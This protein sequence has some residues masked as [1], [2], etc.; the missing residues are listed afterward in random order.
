[1]AISDAQYAAWLKSQ[2]AVRCILVEV[3]V[4]VGASVI[5][6]YLSTQGYVTGATDT[7]A[8]TFYSPRIVGGLQ[9]SRKLSIDGNI[10]MSFG[11]IELN[12]VDGVLD[13]WIDD[14]WANRSLRIYLGDVSWA[15]AD[16]RLVFSGVTTGIDTR[17][18]TS[19]N[20]KLSD[21]LQNLNNPVSEV[22]LGGATSRADDLVPILLGECHNIEPLLTD[23]TINEYQVHNGPVESIFEVRD[24]GIP[25]AFTSLSAIGK[26]RLTNAP[27]GT[28]T[29]SAQGYAAT[30]NYFQY[31]QELDNVYWSKSNCSVTANATSAPDGTTTADKLVE[32]TTASVTHFVSRAVTVAA[33]LPYTLSAYFKAAERSRCRLSMASTLFVGS[34][35]AIVDLTN[36]AVIQEQD[37]TVTVS[38]LASGWYRISMTATTDA[39]G[40]ATMAVYPV[41][42]GT[43]QYTG[44][45]VSG[46]YVWGM[47]VEQSN[48][49][50]AYQPTTATP[51]NIY[52]KTVV[53]IIK[54]LATKYGKAN[55]QYTLNDLDI[56]S[57][58]QFDI[59]NPQQV[60]YYIKD[61]GNV[62]DVCNQLAQSIGARLVINNLGKLTL[63]KLDLPQ[64]SAGTTVTASDMVLK[65]LEISQLPPVVASVK[66]GYCKNWTV[67]DT[68]AA[69]LV[70]NS[71]ALFNEEWLTVTR[72]DT[73]AADNYNLFTDPSQEDTYLLTSVDAI[74]E[75]NRRLAMFS[76]QRKVLKYTGFYHLIFENLGNPQTLVHDRFGL[77]GGKTG[78]IISV[79]MD[80]TS[81]HVQ[82]EVLI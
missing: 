57:L 7:P 30:Q 82:F 58:T 63:V 54:V 67:Q 34:P 35:S 15:R 81:P 31:S 20:I 55:L 21:K 71:V 11:D 2:T 3:D 47:Q 45:G 13:T 19:I 40:S 49:P 53:E 51:L 72:T 28:I 42:G 36:A 62:L 32:N 26:F 60:G 24:N 68:L 66:L 29:C 33:G 70:L 56:A 8:N 10:S 12:N 22:K 14:Y 61:R 64:A 75:A 74:N 52:P 76:V 1:M 48:I 41:Q 80:L 44:D 6:R 77:S 4:K 79:S 5:T 9:I 39:S 46:V 16:F 18:R 65:S 69:G 43:S 25:V 38:P 50:S 17:R 27:S 37:C 73:A 78:Q 23:P 59:S